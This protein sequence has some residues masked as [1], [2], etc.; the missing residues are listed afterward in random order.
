MSDLPLGQERSYRT[1]TPR[2]KTLSIV[3]V[4]A[5]HYTAQRLFFVEVVARFHPAAVVNIVPVPILHK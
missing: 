4:V 5:Q 1:P 2:N 3:T